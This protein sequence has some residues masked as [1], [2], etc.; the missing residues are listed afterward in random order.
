[1]QA[2]AANSLLTENDVSQRIHVS[3]AALRRW[4]VERRGPRYLKLGAL[5][6]YRVEDLEAWLNSQ[7][8][9]GDGAR[10]ALHQ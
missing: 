2:T 5:V 10:G 6:R 9:G 1:M 3:L 7:P 8:T 4:R